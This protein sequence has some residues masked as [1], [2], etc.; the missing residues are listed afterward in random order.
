VKRL[1]RRPHAVA[2]RAAA[3]LDGE[4]EGQADEESGVRNHPGAFGS[5]GGSNGSGPTV[6]PPDDG[7]A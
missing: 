1:G 6:A 7:G 2:Q 4:D 5:N 3:I